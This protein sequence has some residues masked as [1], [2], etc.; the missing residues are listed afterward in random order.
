MAHII[1]IVGRRYGRWRVIS[2]HPARDRGGSALWDCL[3]RCGETGI[4]CGYSLRRGES[5]SCG[6]LAREQKRKRLTTHGMT[7]SRAYRCWQAMLQRCLNPRCPAYPNYGGRGISVCDRWRFG[8]DGKSGFEI[9]F[10]DMGV[11]PDGLSLDRRNNSLGYSRQNCR[12][13]TPTMQIANRRPHKRKRRA[14]VAEIRRF[15]D[16]LARAASGSAETAP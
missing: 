13:A 1:N 9:F 8:E 11:P 7:K 14:S 3:C 10:A 4:V 6:C 5:R 15:A 16:A 12:W 2:L